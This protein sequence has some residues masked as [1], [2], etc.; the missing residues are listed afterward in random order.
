MLAAMM[1]GEYEVEAVAGLA[2]GKLRKKIG[3]LKEA[4][5]GRLEPHHASC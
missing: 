2:G 3:A 5:E 4:L 1:E